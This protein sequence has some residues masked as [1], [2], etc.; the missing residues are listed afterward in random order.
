MMKLLAITNCLQCPYHKEISDPG[1][2]DSFDMMDTSIAC[3]KAPVWEAH[4]DR[5][6]PEG[7]RLIS[8]SERPYRHKDIIERQGFPAFCPLSKVEIKTATLRPELKSKC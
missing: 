6:N 1:S 8:V 4:K 2:D 5:W 7:W 3:T